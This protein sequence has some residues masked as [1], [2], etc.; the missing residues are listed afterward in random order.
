MRQRLPVW[1]ILLVISG[2]LAQGFCAG[3][4][5]RLYYS[6]HAPFFDSMS[7][8]DQLAEVMSA[9]K[10]GGI[11]EGLHSAFTRRTVF[12]PWMIAAAL[13][14]VLPYSRLVGVWIQEFWMAVL[15]VS[16]LIYWRLYRGAPLG[17]ALLWTVPP[18]SFAAVYRVNGG[19]SDFRMDL[20]LYLLFSL[21][22]IWYLATRE[23][24]SRTPWVLSGLFLALCCMNRATAP[25]YLG[26]TLGPL[27]TT[28][29]W[30]EPETRSWL[31]KRVATYW[32]PAAVIGMLPVISS[33]TYIHYYYFVW[34]ADPNANLPLS[35]SAIHIAFAGMNMGIPIAAAAAVLLGVQ[36][37]G[38]IRGFDWV[39]VDWPLVWAACAP[40]L[41]LTV[42]GAGPNPFVSMP[43]VFGALLFCLAP[44]RNGVNT[45]RA[46]MWA[47]V[48]VVAT[49]AYEAR[50]G[51]LDHAAKLNGNT[52][53]MAALKDGIELIRSESRRV[54]L[55]KAEF[56]TAHLA[57][58]QASAL[59]NVLIYEYG[60]VPEGNEF[61]L[62]DGLVL[63]ANYENVFGAAVPL[64][65]GEVPGANDAEKYQHLAD[66]ANE[67][68]DFFFLPDEASID[69]MERERAY[70]YINVKIRGLKR[71]LLGTGAWRK[72][73]PTIRITNQEAVE[74]YVNTRS[75]AGR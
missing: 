21:V 75:G 10:R 7:Y 44:F 2:I 4:W 9:S 18:L 17:L 58:F 5:N 24:K 33:W 32:V 29:W 6:R 41:L 70:N 35:K 59:R 43:T 36:V 26:A 64:S 63:A 38:Q 12:L 46:V 30:F 48:L 22:L 19:V 42:T 55:K 74:L 54:G 61:T 14:P 62:P 51:Y 1:A 39:E 52:P 49:C 20:S 50:A 25:A 65:W 53:S 31:V 72:T 57:D 40:A 27:L 47:S 56:L 15:G 11:A 28:R 60:G 66:L 68:V 69:W 34:G 73:G 3:E 37:A 71:K 23:T 45:S 13:A 16:L 8:N 67:H